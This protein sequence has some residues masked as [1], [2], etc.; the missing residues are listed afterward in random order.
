MLQTYWTIM[1]RRLAAAGAL[2]L[3][4]A[5]TAWSA[6]WETTNQDGVLVQATA[7]DRG[8]VEA[9]RRQVL[10]GRQVV[11]QFFGSEFP[12]PAG[13]KIFADRA[14]LTDYWRQQSQ[15]PDLKPECWMVASGTAQG[16]S[17]L[18]PRVW[19]SQACDHDAADAVALQKLITHELVHV[20][21]GQ[22]NPSPEFDGLEGIDWF[23]EGLANYASGQLDD[24][25]LQGVRKALQAMQGEPLQLSQ[26]WSG[27]DRYGQAGSLVAYLDRRF[28]RAAL[29][30]ML[31]C[32]TPRQ[33]M[34]VLGMTEAQLI[35]DWRASVSH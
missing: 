30:R 29:V 13:V 22:S 19:S 10:A 15:E 4:G 27:S 14:T 24:K 35:A 7:P 5:T 3:A 9:V 1:A 23:V 31:R 11:T 2:A 12:K 16:L 18:S 28:G 25:R 21:H 34:D 17:L 6:E 26:V 20:F 32:T 33:L 8:G